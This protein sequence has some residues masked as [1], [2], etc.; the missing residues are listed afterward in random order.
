V[1]PIAS[2]S[3]ALSFKKRLQRKGFTDRELQQLT[4]PLGKSVETGNSPMEVAIAV[5]ADLLTTR[6]RLR[7]DAITPKAAMAD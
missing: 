5:C 3:K 7:A 4:A 1:I 2:D 6:Q